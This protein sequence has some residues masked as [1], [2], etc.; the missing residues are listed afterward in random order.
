MKTKLNA[1]WKPGRIEMLNGFILFIYV[2][3]SQFLKLF[4][5]N[6]LQDVSNVTKI[7]EEREQKCQSLKMTAQPI[8]II[9]GTYKS[10]QCFVSVNEQL[11]K[12]ENP[13]KA[14]DLC[15][16]VIPWNPYQPGYSYKEVYSIIFIPS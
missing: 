1:H 11:Y 14:V 13:L 7:I 10:Y 16:K 8:P 6:L 12:V 3:F 2:S 4:L 5:F 15:F 9:V